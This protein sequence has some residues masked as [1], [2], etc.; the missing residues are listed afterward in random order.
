MNIQHE[1]DIGH[2]L[3]LKTKKHHYIFENNSLWPAPL[4]LICINC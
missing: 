3:V 1:N 4:F 2:K